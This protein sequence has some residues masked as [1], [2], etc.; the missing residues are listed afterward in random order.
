MFYRVIKGSA[1]YDFS[2]LQTYQHLVEAGA[3]YTYTCFI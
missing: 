3:M 1:A 2:L